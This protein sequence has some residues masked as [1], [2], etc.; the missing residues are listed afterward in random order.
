MFCHDI[1]CYVSHYK[2]QNIHSEMSILLHLDRN[3]SC[4]FQSGFSVWL[5]KKNCEANFVFK[6]SIF[7][8]P[9]KR[10]MMSEIMSDG[11]SALSSS[12]FLGD[13]GNG[14]GS[15]QHQQ[16]PETS[17]HHAA[18]RLQNACSDALYLSSLY[19]YSF[20]IFKRFAYATQ[21][22]PDRT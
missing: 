19:A 7:L 14:V 18:W 2:R 20:V 10:K 12:G 22:L 15:N 13:S 3:E 9:R 11:V 17:M 16:Q 8:L 6:S 1:K 5:G 4:L 21:V